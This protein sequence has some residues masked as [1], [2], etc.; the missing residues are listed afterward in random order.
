[1]PYLKSIYSND[2]CVVLNFTGIEYKEDINPRWIRTE[3][4]FGKQK[5]Q[6]SMADCDIEE[7]IFSLESV[8]EGEKEH[9]SITTMEENFK[10][11]VYK[12]MD[13]RTVNHTTI[14]IWYGE[15]V[16]I[17]IRFNTSL[18]ILSQFKDDLKQVV[19]SLGLT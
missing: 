10:F 9:F 1:M 13:D 19:I 2:K 3:C 8:I 6:F 15:D 11:K 14:E 5:H 18:E 16:M 4:I 7:L 17:G 12:N